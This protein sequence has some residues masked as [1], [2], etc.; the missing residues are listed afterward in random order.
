MY[1]KMEIIAA[2]L[3]I[4][5]SGSWLRSVRGFIECVFPEADG[6][7]GVF[8]TGRIGI[9]AGAIAMSKVALTTAIKFGH[10]RRQFGPTENN[11]DEVPIITYLSHQV[12]NVDNTS[13]SWFSKE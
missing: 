13:V 8:S 11:E 3:N 6:I 5:A 7:L 10:F 2:P 9:A 4:L 12:R 1:R